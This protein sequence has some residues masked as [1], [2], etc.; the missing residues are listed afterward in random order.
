VSTGRN[1]FLR[2]KKI[3]L[4]FSSILKSVPFNLRKS[5]FYHARMI[6]GKKGILIRYILLKS[7]LRKC[8]DNVSIHSNVYLLNI[9][10][11]NLGNNVS[12]HPMCYIDATGFIEIG[13]NVSIAHMVTI[14]STEHSYNNSEIPIKYQDVIK[15]KTIIADN[16][17]V[18]AKSTILS[19]VSIDEGSI[20]AAG[21]VVT[22][23][24]IKNVI[25]G[26]VPAKI[27]KERL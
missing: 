12:I 17:W 23:D 2:Y 5:L 10:R 4:F 6:S 24:V 25:V 15:Q 9:D 21:A 26:G 8:G 27:I 11:L 14:M 19:G 16:V 20:V 3:M 1:Q 18:G 13:N 22:K 7:I